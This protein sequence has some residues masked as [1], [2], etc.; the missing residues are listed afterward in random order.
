VR[1]QAVWKRYKA[2]HNYC[3]YRNFCIRIQ[4]WWR[5][6]HRAVFRL[7][8]FYD[9]AMIKRMFM[10]LPVDSSQL[11]VFP[12]VYFQQL[13]H[14]L[15]QQ[16]A[17][18]RIVATIRCCIQRRQ[19]LCVRVAVVQIQRWYRHHRE[20]RR[21]AAETVR[22]NEE[23]QEEEPV[24]PLDEFEIFNTLIL[25]NI[26]KLSQKE[27]VELTQMNTITNARYTRSVEFEVVRKQGPRPPSPNAKTLSQFAA[28]ARKG[29]RVSVGKG[30]KQTKIRWKLDKQP[31]TSLMR[32]PPTRVT[33]IK[34]R[35]PVKRL[36][37]C[38]RVSYLLKLVFTV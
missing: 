4:K 1:I 32:R 21:I 5:Q 33:C 3:L 7:R 35:H 24:V 11:Q 28:V 8:L 36:K 2:H 37:S 23:G 27:L 31:L 17:A 15:I 10:R 25:P 26:A 22:M 6:R 38:L 30:G 9:C 14:S 12:S 16:D 13:H 20:Q 18:R 29:N 34:R 19:F